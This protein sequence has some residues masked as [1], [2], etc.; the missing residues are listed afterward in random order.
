VFITTDII[1]E[2]FGKKGVRTISWLTVVL[3][4]YTFLMVSIITGLSPADYWQQLNSTDAAGQPFDMNYAYNKV[5]TQGMNIIVASMVAFMIGQLL[6]VFIFQRLRRITGP[7]MIWLR[8]TGSTL[9]SQLVDSFVVLFIAFYVAGNWPMSL[10]ISVC[11][12]NYI[13]KFVVAVALTPVLYVVHYF[14]DRYL[15][16]DQ[17]HAMAD[18]ATAESKG[19]F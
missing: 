8:A 19:F 10:V 1:N 2:Y 13:Y 12:V 3:I 5:Y 14:I 16:K 18:E 6:D 4:G 15:G 7:K 17:A 11:I 9:V